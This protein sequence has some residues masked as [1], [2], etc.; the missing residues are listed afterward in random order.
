MVAQE[1]PIV[2]RTTCCNTCGDLERRYDIEC[3]HQK[4]LTSLTATHFSQCSRLIYA[5]VAMEFLSS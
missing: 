4:T 2:L 1:R 3:A 5:P